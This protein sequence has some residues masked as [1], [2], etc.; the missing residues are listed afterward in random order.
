[1]PSAPKG[2]LMA[3]SKGDDLGGEE[4]NKV[5]PVLKAD[6]SVDEELTLFKVARSNPIRMF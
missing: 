2:S 5:E 6:G 3:I 1:M 4:I